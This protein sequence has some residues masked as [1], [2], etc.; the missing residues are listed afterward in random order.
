[1][2][3]DIQA[4]Q[5]IAQRRG[6]N[7]NQPI[8]D[9]LALKELLEKTSHEF[10]CILTPKQSL[11]FEDFEKYGLFDYIDWSTETKNSKYIRNQNHYN[12]ERRLYMFVL[13]GK[14]DSN[15]T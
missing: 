15:A 8:N 2:L 14:G 11:I 13:K 6:F 10:L 5:M 4:W 3:F 12:G 1:M 7:S 9:F